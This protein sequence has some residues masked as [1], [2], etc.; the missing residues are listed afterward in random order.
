[1]EDIILTET[2]ETYIETGIDYSSDL[3]LILQQLSELNLYLQLLVYT[4]AFIISLLLAWQVWKY[5][6][7]LLRS[8]IKFPI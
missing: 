6:R 3:E 2:I 8:Y 5:I 4:V 1:M 7:G